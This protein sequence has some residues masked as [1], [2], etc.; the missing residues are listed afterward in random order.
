M[1]ENINSSRTPKYLKGISALS[2]ISEIQSVTHSSVTI[3]RDSET[4]EPSASL[5]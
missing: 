5:W 2:P 1:E 3:L 4:P